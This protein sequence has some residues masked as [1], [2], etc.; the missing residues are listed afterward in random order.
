MD[1]TFNYASRTYSTIRQ[2]LLNRAANVAPDWTD[3]DPSDFGMLF[4]DLWSYMGDIMNYYIDRAGRE[5]FI[6]T[7]TQRESLLAYANMFGYRPSGRVSSTAN[8]NVSNQSGAST[9][10]YTFDEGS[11][12][13][14]SSGGVTYNFYSVAEN[15][16]YPGQSTT[17]ELREG[18]QIFDETLVSSAS[19]LPNQTYLLANSDADLSTIG[20]SV[21]EEGTATTWVRYETIQDIPQNSRGFSVLLAASGKVQINFG[22]RIN[23]FI[24][25]AGST[26]TTN[27]TRSSGANG[28]IGS[29]LIKTLTSSTP[30][31]IVIASSTAATGGTNGETAETL[32][33]NIISYIRTQD[34]AV[35]LK[36]YE[37]LTR[38]VNGVYKAV[39]TY[40]PGVG[41]ASGG[42]SVILYGLPYISNF[43]TLQDTNTNSI[44]VP[45][46][47]KT[48]IV[49]RI[50]PR[51]M[52]GVKPIA[53]STIVLDKLNIIAAV[54]VSDGFVSSAVASNVY[55]A[56]DG[57]LD[58][59][60][61][62]FGKQIRKADVYKAVMAI[63]GVDY[64]E[65]S[66]FKIV[67]S[68]G[69]EITVLDPT[70]LI[71]KGS[72]SITFSGGMVVS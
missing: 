26:I 70:H 35:T 63:N 10:M 48:A 41:S 28:N 21:T 54:Y 5:S 31:Y 66:E 59:D 60:A 20:V 40:T 50:T 38:A 47:I 34:R 22:N 37:D 15:I 11:K 25:P 62:D 14:A 69:T 57:L 61:T 49:D 9:N 53:A 51:S 68:V 58:F 30:S 64:I 24:P 72:V 13:T 17:I 52:L 39:A 36:D 2:D 46:S 1:N 44:T 56:I 7:A 42:A 32:K 18:T 67:N 4:V 19:G 45:S 16:V 27:Y 29:N 12:F 33:S 23:G 55:N 43:L 8:V 65:I 3:R 71:R 6:T